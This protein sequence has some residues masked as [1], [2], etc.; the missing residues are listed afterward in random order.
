MSTIAELSIEIHEN[1]RNKG[2]WDGEVNVGEKLM[3]IVSEA[4]EALEADRNRCFCDW[5]FDEPPILQVD[6]LDD[7]SF[8]EQF[9]KYVKNK[10]EDE[11]ADIV[12][13]VM[14]FACF[15]GMDLE[16]HIKQ[17]MRYNKTRPHMHGKKY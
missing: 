8:K 9:E 16:W 12:I 4:S 2:F 10:M 6:Q 3:L 7:V 17:K 1:A 14:D 13:R 11:L 15:R 5:S